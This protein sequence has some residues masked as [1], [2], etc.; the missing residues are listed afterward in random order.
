MKLT[1]IRF[2]EEADQRLRHLKARTTLT[3]NLLCR[4]GFS[5]SL[6][7]PTIPDPAHYPEDSSREI[8]RPTLTGQYDILFLALLRERC[9]NDRLPIDGELFEAQF[10]AHMNRGVLM[11]FQRVK[12]L[13]D[14]CK[15]APT[16]LH[17]LTPESSM[18]IR[19]SQFAVLD[20]PDAE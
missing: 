5:L 2:C 17:S 9:A 8:D 13:A 12:S 20:E 3:A 18:V 16:Q 19:S 11:L 1:R 14:L 7:D 6:E 4:I 15:L 10:R